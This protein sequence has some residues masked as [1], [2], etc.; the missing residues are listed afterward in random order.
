MAVCRSTVNVTDFKQEERMFVPIVSLTRGKTESHNSE[1]AE[2]LII[3]VTFWDSDDFN[4][5]YFEYG[6]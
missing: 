4:V 5:F 2:V 3:T 6:T 1:A